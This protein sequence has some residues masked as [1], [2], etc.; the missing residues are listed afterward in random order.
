MNTKD[1]IQ[2]HRDAPQ[3]SRR[4]RAGRGNVTGFVMSPTMGHSIDFESGN[5]ERAAIWHFEFTEGIEEIYSQPTPLNLGLPDKNGVIRSAD[6]TF[7]F[8]LVDPEMEATIVEC[9]RVK[10]LIELANKNP[11]RWKKEKNGKWRSPPMDDALRELGFRFLLLTDEDLNPHLTANFEYLAS[12]LDYDTLAPTELHQRIGNEVVREP[13]TI[14]SICESVGCGAP[15]VMAAFELGGIHID[16]E[17][18]LLARPDITSVYKNKLVAQAYAA[19]QKTRIPIKGKAII[20]SGDVLNLD[21][22][23]LNI[24]TIGESKVYVR[25]EKDGALREYDK[26]DILEL[27]A[28]ESATL[29]KV[30]P[31]TEVKQ[32]IAALIH[33]ASPITLKKALYKA[34]CAAGHKKPEN[35]ESKR[36]LQR[37]RKR[38]I[39]S[40]RFYG[41]GFAIFLE[42][43]RQGHRQRRMQQDVYEVMEEVLRDYYLT[44]KAPS[45]AKVYKDLLD[46]CEERGLTAPARNTLQKYLND[47]TIESERLQKRLNRRAAYAVTPGTGTNYDPH[48]LGEFA[49]HRAHIDA[50]Q[51]D[52]V[53]VCPR[54]GK[55]LG[56]PWLTVVIAPKVRYILGYTL[57]FESPSANTTMVALRDVYKRMGALPTEIV[58]DNGKEFKNLAISGLLAAFGT[59]VTYRPPY[60][61]RFGPIMERWF[62][63]IDQLMMHALAGSTHALS[64]KTGVN[65]ENDPRIS[66]C[67]ELGGIDEAINGF[68]DTYHD[69]VHTSLYMTPNEAMRR[70]QLIHPNG[71][72]VDH[73]TLPYDACKILFLPDTAGQTLKVQAGRGVCHQ[74]HW[75]WSDKMIQSEVEGKSFETKYDPYDLTKVYL[76][77]NDSWERPRKKSSVN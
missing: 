8:L 55:S 72:S 73:M 40:N 12:C 17:Q 22:V 27:L 49:M 38:L 57:T 5:P 30:S 31:Q 66:A 41:V 68:I 74:Y 51:L 60:T 4:V 34:S 69:Q 71:N 59:H 7:D 39:E 20:S 46:I 52:I 61:P 15:S 32:E 29:L 64:K 37:W 6:R 75:Y 70:D 45:V 11:H 9:K 63:T 50:K 76:Y 36:T 56:R 3:A 26:D 35:E 25:K 42:P 48:Y 19:N 13:K 1:Y 28:K 43:V 47:H 33:K 24:D 67:W 44:K 54:T 62:G 23:P 14:Q 10:D 16:L 21:G 58:M 53:L 77:I 65:K 2:A 18:S